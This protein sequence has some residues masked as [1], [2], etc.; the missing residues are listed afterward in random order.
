MI[1]LHK[2]MHMAINKSHEF[3]CT[4][5]NMIDVVYDCE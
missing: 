4:E 1:V 5:S 2:F 3:K